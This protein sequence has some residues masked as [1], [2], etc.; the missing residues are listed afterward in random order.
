M[1]KGPGG[2]KLCNVRESGPF[3]VVLEWAGRQDLA[4]N[5]TGGG[6]GSRR[7]LHACLKTEL[8]DGSQ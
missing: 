2:R 1:C 3:Q 8:D 6:L 4:E 7:T 5:V